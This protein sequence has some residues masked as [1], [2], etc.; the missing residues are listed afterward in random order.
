MNTNFFEHETVPQ[1]SSVSPVENL[2][3]EV[4]DAFDRLASIL[5]T[6]SVLPSLS[7]VIGS[8]L[9]LDVNYHGFEN[10]YTESFSIESSTK[11]I[12]LATEPTDILSVSYLN[13]TT[14][15]EVYLDSKLPSQEFTSKSEFK[16]IG[17]V[18]SLSGDYS[19]I[20]LKVKYRGIRKEFGNLKMILIKNKNDQSKKIFVFRRR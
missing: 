20:T 8:Y 11:D 14:N 17:R 12:V 13:A 15:T 18:L 7:S 10:E 6:T 5:N 1:N 4:G 3:I 9:L 19:S 16:V 2:A